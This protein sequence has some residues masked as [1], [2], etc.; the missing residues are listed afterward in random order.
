MQ[1]NNQ[2]NNA[3]RFR[4]CSVGPMIEQARPF[5]VASIIEHPRPCSVAPVWDHLYADPRILGF[6]GAASPRSYIYIYIRIF[7][8]FL[9]IHDKLASTLTITPQWHGF[10]PR[11]CSEAPIMDTLSASLPKV[12]AAGPGRIF[13]RPMQFFPPGEVP[14]FC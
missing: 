4:P 5:S 12:A 13:L 3:Q 9:L 8:L 10:T 14:I 2:A 6:H 1:S 11:P 7:S